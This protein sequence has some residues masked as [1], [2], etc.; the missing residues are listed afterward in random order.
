MKI[1]VI[2][3]LACVAPF[4]MQCTRISFSVVYEIRINESLAE[5]ESSSTEE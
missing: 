4:H 2:R 1:L 5:V 3:L